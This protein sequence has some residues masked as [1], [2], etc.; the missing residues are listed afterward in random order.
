MLENSYIAKVVAHF[1]HSTGPNY[2][3]LREMT[4][5]EDRLFLSG[6]ADHEN[7]EIIAL[8]TVEGLTIIFIGGRQLIRN[9]MNFDEHEFMKHLRGELRS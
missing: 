8:K 1:V 5:G 9:P 3:L 2:Y 6:Y 4:G 7:A